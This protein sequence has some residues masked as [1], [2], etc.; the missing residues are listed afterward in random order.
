MNFR[1]VYIFP[2]VFL[3]LFISSCKKVQKQWHFER[4]I[5]LPIES[6]PLALAKDG[7]TI[8]FSDPDYFRLFRIDLNG[9]VL[10][11]IIGIQRPMNIHSDKKSLYIP[12]FLTDT[13]WKYRNGRLNPLQIKKRPQAPAGVSVYGDTVAI[14]DFYNHR[15]IIQTADTS[16]TIGKQGHQDVKLYYPIDVKLRGSKVYVA[17]AYNHRVQV[18]GFGGKHLKTIGLNDQINVASGIEL[19]SQEIAVTDQENDR[20][21]IYGYDGQLFQVLEEGINY[22]TDVLLDMEYLYI[23]NFKEN[24][25]SVYQKR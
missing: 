6:R 16:V 23:T 19:N 15:I 3:L 25:I 5:M 11:S 17:D 9:R 24:S 13:I 14:A 4:K 18:F 10:D 7:E 2:V 12:E 20:V 22:P 1:K 8:W 21:L